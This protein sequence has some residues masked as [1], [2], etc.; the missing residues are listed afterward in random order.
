MLLSVSYSSEE[1][2][3]IENVFLSHRNN[4]ENYTCKAVDRLRDTSAARR[5]KSRVYT[6]SNVVKYCPAHQY[7]ITHISII[8]S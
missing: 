4:R 6:W 3:N 1:D 7:I 2:H 8:E 5:V